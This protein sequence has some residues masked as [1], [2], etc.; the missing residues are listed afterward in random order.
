MS[1]TLALSS[2]Q[3]FPLEENVVLVPL[4]S[5]WQLN[6]LSNSSTPVFDF[7]KNSP[8]SFMLTY[9][10]KPYSAYRI[11]T[12]DG[13]TNLKVRGS[14]VYE[15]SAS[16]WLGVNSDWFPVANYTQANSTQYKEIQ[17]FTSPPLTIPQG[18]HTA[19]V[20]FTIEGDR[21]GITQTLSS[22]QIPVIL[23]VFEEG[24]F[25]SPDKLQ[26]FYEEFAVTLPKPLQIGG[27]NYTAHFPIGLLPTGDGVVENVDGS[28]QVSGSGLKTFSVRLATQ[29][30][31]VIGSND[32]VVL[33]VIISYPTTSYTIPVTV[34]RTGGVYPTDISFNI[35]NGAV[36][37]LFHIIHINRGDAF[38]VALATNS[39][40]GYEILDTPDG[41]KLKV[42]VINPKAFGSGT[43]NRSLTLSFSNAT[44]II[45]IA[46]T[47]G[48]QFDLG[49]DL[50]TVFTHSMK[51]LEFSSS[52]EGSYVD[53]LLTVVGQSTSFHYQFPFFKGKAY[54]N[55]GKALS[56]FVNNKLQQ[57]FAFPL[58]VINQKNT[59]VYSL[60]YFNLQV[61]ERKNNVDLVTFNK[62]N[63]PFVLGYEP[64][65]VNNK[66]ILQH[67]SFSRFTPRSFAL[68]SI[69]SQTG[70]FDYKILKNGTQV[71]AATQ[72]F[73]YLRSIEL[74]FENYDAVPG[75]IIDLILITG[76][77]E[78]KKSFV[79]FPE[80][81]NSIDVVYVDS[82]GL[83]S[84]LNFTGNVK[85]LLAEFDF[86]T[87]TYQKHSFLHTRK[88]LQKEKNNLVLN[89]G[90]LLKGQ[91]LE[92]AELMK[93]TKAWIVIDGKKVVELIPITD[94]VTEQS[95][96][97][98]LYSYSIEFEINKDKYAQDY[99]F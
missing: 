18:V 94:K 54:K 48:N 5:N 39:N 40:I 15:T 9:Q 57:E 30:N 37:E 49:L 59:N 27:S 22:Y 14:I 72:L 58:N 96:E 26:F 12:L 81:Q 92:V 95:N 86:K 8:Q 75:D 7:M 70:S 41:K 68:I 34:I 66:A 69:Y 42:N 87:E 16:G 43:V 50:G 63:V 32:S 36:D 89:T 10:L 33:P 71:Y 93:S 78:I 77:E 1:F 44:Y 55:I 53:L 35:Q 80:G 17:F 62:S 83:H 3:I 11:F 99:N 52:N 29:I 97:D 91:S 56:N 24:S 84:V 76:S 38:S 46:I 4:A 82:F 2:N 45:D 65:V 67:N 64:K 20:R 74:Y 60:N 79:I 25:Y 23:N 51:D 88:Y 28:Y 90:F 85:N 98:F 31:S 47:I 61:R 13:F 73:G 19:K 21:N 6:L